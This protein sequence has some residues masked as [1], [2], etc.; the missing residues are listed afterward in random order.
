MK[1][2]ETPGVRT[3]RTRGRI[4]SR[5]LREDFWGRPLW[6]WLVLGALALGMNYLSYLM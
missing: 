1:E 5:G 6:Q 4:Y 3:S 2:R